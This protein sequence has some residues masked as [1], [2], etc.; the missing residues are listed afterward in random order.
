MKVL[1][2]V[3]G[4]GRSGGYR[5]LSL[6]AN[7]LMDRGMEVY[8]MSPVQSG[9][10]YFPTRAPVIWVDK[11]GERRE[12]P[13]AG[14]GGPY[15]YFICL[16][17]GLKKQEMVN[18]SDIILV[19]HSLTV[20]PAVLAGL[21]QKAVYYVQAYEPELY[22]SMR[23]IKNR[24]LGKLAE[25]TYRL[26]LFTIVNQELY[27][28]Y[29]KLQATRVLY[30]GVDKKIFY[31]GSRPAGG[32]HKIVAGTVGRKEKYKGTCYIIEA[33]KR[34]QKKYDGLELH[35]AYGNPDDFKGIKGIYCC[36]P[37]ND[38]ELADFYRSLDFYIC[39]GFIQLGAFHYPIAEAM[40]CMIPVI[41]TLYFPASDANA[42][43]VAPE[44]AESIIE[45]FEAAMN[46]PAEAKEK[47]RQAFCD[48]EDLGWDRAGRIL[49]KF[50]KEKM[51]A[52]S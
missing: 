34:L 15:S 32:G 51:A 14:R 16:L 5:V 24:L 28:N 21:K 8:F 2:P 20:F 19:N 50:L 9:H 23:W 39:A 47:A 52:V 17:R 36:T 43:I 38:S 1:I 13:V 44:N 26:G 45:K 30:P 33:F 27:L 12:H 29:K 6:L 3:W 31:P 22:Y 25:R 49:E 42:W 40:S 4:F 11:K 37:A 48:V 18:S 46:H 35:V 41:T 7:E 10:P